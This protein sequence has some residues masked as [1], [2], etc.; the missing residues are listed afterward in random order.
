MRR[1]IFDGLRLLEH[2]EDLT[3][4]DALARALPKHHLLSIFSRADKAVWPENAEFPRHLVKAGFV[5]QKPLDESPGHDEI[6]HR[7]C[8]RVETHQALRA[9]LQTQIPSER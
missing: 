3:P 1:D 4:E 9:W 5:V 6:H 7:L 8:S 2:H